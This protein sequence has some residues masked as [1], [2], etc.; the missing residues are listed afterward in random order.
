MYLI[1]LLK[2]NNAVP[3]DLVETDAVAATVLKALSNKQY[4]G[5][6]FR[7]AD[8]KLNIMS[9]AIKQSKWG[10]MEPQNLVNA[11]ISLGK[12]YDIELTALKQAV[13][14]EI[15]QHLQLSGLSKIEA[16]IKVSK[17]LDTNSELTVG[18]Y[19]CGFNGKT[20]YHNVVADIPHG[21]LTEPPKYSPGL[22]TY[23]TLMRDKD[24]NRKVWQWVIKN[25]KNKIIFVTS[26]VKLIIFNNDR[27]I[28]NSL[29]LKMSPYF[30]YF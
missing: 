28:K 14:A 16:S 2:E 18:N 25:Y 3:L 4:N 20:F 27:H 11:L 23:P 1:V 9:N 24:Q 30:G 12:K 10:G 21:V 19:I 15:L 8:E 26:N 17:L 22:T 6:I 29:K 5:L 13:A 7:G